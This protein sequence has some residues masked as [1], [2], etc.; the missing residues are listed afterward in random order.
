MDRDA[1]RTKNPGNSSLSPIRNEEQTNP[2]KQ[3]PKEKC[4]R[5]LH[6]FGQEHRGEAEG[7]QPHKTD[8]RRDAKQISDLIH[9]DGFLR[10][11]RRHTHADSVSQVVP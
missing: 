11:V 1:I 10:A 4:D 3:C 6:R 7:Y 5:D 9:W 8:C 2:A